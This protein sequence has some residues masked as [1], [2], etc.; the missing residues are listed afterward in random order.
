MA[1]AAERTGGR[2][3]DAPD[4]RRIPT[5][6]LT[7]IAFLAN[8]G[9]R[10][11]VLESLVE[12]PHSRHVLAE[13]VD[14]SRVTLARILDGLEERRWIRQ[15]GTRARITPLGG[16]VLEE[17]AAL[18]AMLEHERRLRDVID[19]L[20]ADGFGFH[21]S[22]LTTAEITRRRKA[23]PAAP[24]ASLVDALE[25]PDEIRSFSFSITDPWLE[26]CWRRITA[27]ELRWTWVCTPEVIDIMNAD[28]TMA[29]RAAEIL[30]TGRA[31]FYTNPDVAAVVL[32]AE[33][34]VHIRL[35]D[36][37]GIP[38]ALVQTDDEHVRAWAESTFETYRRAGVRVD[39]TAFTA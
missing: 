22:A 30:E 7:D 1:D 34:R 3:T 17:F 12:A 8:S 18:C 19:L 16:W 27:G 6:S 5:E 29:A 2:M 10:V 11:A 24:I 37:D 28:P 35:V 4:R 38:A 13:M 31:E 23:D 9:N 39:A 25:T 15:D 14:V 26:T 32:L 21:V 20:P 36:D 33:G